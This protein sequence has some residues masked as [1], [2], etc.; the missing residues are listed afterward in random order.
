MSFNQVNFSDKNARE[1][2]NVKRLD[3]LL[4]MVFD[5]TQQKESNQ[6][7]QNGQTSAQI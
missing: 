1:T 3:A 5:C 2:K 7:D 6:L 4:K